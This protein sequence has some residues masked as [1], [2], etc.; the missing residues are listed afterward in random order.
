LLKIRQIFSCL[1]EALICQLMSSLIISVIRLSTNMPQ[2]GKFDKARIISYVENGYSTSESL[3][4]ARFAT[5]ISTKD[6]AA[7]HN[8]KVMSGYVYVVC[9]V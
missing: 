8:S 3:E 9:V 7:C 1:N 6:F 2:I 4:E 5:S